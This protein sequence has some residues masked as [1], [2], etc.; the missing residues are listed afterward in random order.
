MIQKEE[1]EKRRLGDQFVEEGSGKNNTIIEQEKE[2]DTDTESLSAWQ[3]EWD[4]YFE[5]R[6]KEAEEDQEDPEEEEEIEEKEAQD[7]KDD[8]IIN[9]PNFI[10]NE[11]EE[12]RWGKSYFQALGQDPLF[13][14]DKKLRHPFYLN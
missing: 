6:G 11:S 9:E 2:N 4:E 5:K 7:I 12:T 14:K 1:V 13:G 10:W 8:G 3:S